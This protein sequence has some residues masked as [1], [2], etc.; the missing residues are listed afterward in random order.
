[1]QYL[2]NYRLEAACKANGRKYAVLESLSLILKIAAL[3]LLVIFFRYFYIA[4][5]VWVVSVFVN[6]FKRNLLYKY[7]YSLENGTLTVIKEFTPEKKIICEKLDVKT[8]ISN[9]SIGE[10]DTRYY[11]TPTNTI[12]KIEKI[13]GGS[14]SLAA[15]KY[16]Y[17]L[18]DYYKREV[19][20]DLS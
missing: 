14:F 3:L 9:F 2:S 6:V 11:E 4:I 12:I 15:D 1:M 20:N 7:V 17:G 5:A 19:C 13:E 18:I 8:Q 16:F 10:T